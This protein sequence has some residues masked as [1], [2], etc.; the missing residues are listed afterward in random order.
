MLTVA[1]VMTTEVFSVAPNTSIREVAKLMHMKHISGVPVVDRG[2]RVIGIASEGDIK[3][4][5][6]CWRT[7][8][9]LVVDRLHQHEGS[10][11]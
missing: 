8:P 2:N 4:R 6:A 11:G 1:D 7:A 9:A 3:A 5:C 10:G